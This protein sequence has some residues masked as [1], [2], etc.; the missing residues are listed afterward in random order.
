MKNINSIDINRSAFSYEEVIQNNFYADYS[1]NAEWI[2]VERPENIIEDE[3]IENS[4]NISK[5]FL[6]AS[7]IFFFI[8]VGFGR[9]IAEILI[10]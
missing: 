7:I 1:R 3:T 8:V 9:N 5:V 6:I 10:K 4:D 2:E